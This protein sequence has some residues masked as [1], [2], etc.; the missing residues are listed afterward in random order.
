MIGTTIFKDSQ[1]T[2]GDEVETLVRHGVPV[3]VVG[4][5]H[6]HHLITLSLFEVK[7]EDEA[8]QEEELMCC[9]GFPRKIFD[10][11][12]HLSSNCIGCVSPWI[13]DHPRNL[14]E[15]GNRSE[16]PVWWLGRELDLFSACCYS[17]IPGGALYAV[18]KVFGWGCIEAPP[19]LD[20]NPHVRAHPR[21]GAYATSR[22]LQSSDISTRGHSRGTGPC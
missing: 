19:L 20:H 17:G 15:N 11:F 16:V 4:F 7:D 10:I 2:I 9:S 6:L 13:I 3:F 12:V 1:V 22:Y 21:P 18:G 14:R 5:V 8:K